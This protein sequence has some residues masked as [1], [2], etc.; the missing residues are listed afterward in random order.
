MTTQTLAEVESDLINARA[1]LAK[2]RHAI[3]YGIGDRTVGRAKLPELVAEV[4]RLE[5]LV[6][7]LTDVQNGV[8]NPDFLVPKWS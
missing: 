3:Q 1:A 6:R 2:A 8:D 5:R 4:A 7:A